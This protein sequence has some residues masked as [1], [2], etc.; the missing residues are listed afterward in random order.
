[1]KAKAK[2]LALADFHAPDGWSVAHVDVTRES[3]VKTRVPGYVHPSAPGLAVTVPVTK[4][5]LL[6]GK[7]VITHIASGFK[8][9]FAF[10]TLAAA[11]A[12]ALRIAPLGDWTRD[13]SAISADSVLRDR[14]AVEMAAP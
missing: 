6:S 3:N 8:I 14:V 5:E 1:V 2:P 12:A 9:P 13:F 4:M 10:P 7:H 11:C